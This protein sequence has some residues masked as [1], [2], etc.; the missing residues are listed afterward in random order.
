MNAQRTCNSITEGCGSTIFEER[1]HGP[2]HSHH[3]LNSISKLYLDFALSCN[4]EL[5]DILNTNI[6]IFTTC[7]EFDWT[8]LVY[9]FV[10]LVVLDNVTVKKKATGLGWWV[11]DT[12]H[13]TGFSRVRDE[14]EGQILGW[15]TCK[16]KIK[17][18]S[19][20]CVYNC[21]ESCLT[22]LASI[23]A[24]PNV[25]HECVQRIILLRSLLLDINR[26]HSPI[27]RIPVTALKQKNCQVILLTLIS[28]PF[29]FEFTTIN[30]RGEIWIV[31]NQLEGTLRIPR[32]FS[33]PDRICPLY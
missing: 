11:S 5:K 8:I 9:C 26:L 30:I 29:F 14:F 2:L 33:S 16:Y 19:S 13:N 20:L 28:V 10:P 17:N 15:S 3:R 18:M 7:F 6:S 27:P 4:I 25:V 21:R 32:F 12:Y 1:I 23:E 22:N 24:I 31:S